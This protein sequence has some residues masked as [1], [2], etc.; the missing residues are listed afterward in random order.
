MPASVLFVCTGNICRSPMAAAIARATLARTGNADVE[1]ASAGIFAVEGQGVTSDAAAIAEEHGLDLGG[2]SAQQLTRELA[3]GA[4]LVVA[5]EDEHADFA[6]RLGARNVV[7]LARPV[8]DPYG[9]GAVVYRDTW[10]L[11]TTLVPV[12]LREA[13]LLRDNRR[14]DPL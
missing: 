8:R 12:A 3:T 4:T 10:A 14:G 1:V 7:T 6:A 9:R 5:M 11:L 2:H 13:G